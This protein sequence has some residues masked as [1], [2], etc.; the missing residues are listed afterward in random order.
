[1]YDCC[2]ATSAAHTYGNM[3]SIM[4]EYILSLYPKKYFRTEFISSAIGY[5]QFN[6]MRQKNKEFLKKRKPM[7]IMK[8]RIDMSDDDK[9]MYGTLLTERYYDNANAKDYGNLMPF[10]KDEEKGIQIRYLLNRMK[11]S[12]DVT[13]I[14]ETMMEQINMAN[15]LKYRV[16]ENHNFFLHAYLESYIPKNMLS[17]ISELSGVPMYNKDGN[18]REFLDYLNGHSNTPVT[19]KLQDSTG[20]DEFFRFYDANVDTLI[21][22]ISVDDGSKRGQVYDSFATNFTITAEFW[23]VGLF[24]ILSEKPIPVKYEGNPELPET[25]KIIPLFS[26][27]IYKVEA[28]ENWNVYASTFYRV[29]PDPQTGIDVTD[30][31]SIMTDEILAL[32]R[33]HKEEHIGLSV[34][35]KAIVM[36]DNEVLEPEIDYEFD[37]DTFTVITKKIS[38]TKTY[39]L[40]IF[41]NTL[42][43]NELTKRLFN[44]KEE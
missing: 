31:S 30:F 10:F 40:I 35:L 18:V 4:K 16:R 27:P 20:N 38:R 1:M 33:Y 17:V 11:I 15:Y 41:I 37:F 36:A 12:F 2:S 43:V 28:P 39:R 7:L 3:T 26:I 24:Y 32:I 29:D 23:G 25:G 21:S 8:P 6:P 19:Y 13:V 14:H 44:L 34:L 9:F 42:Y 5:S 22:N